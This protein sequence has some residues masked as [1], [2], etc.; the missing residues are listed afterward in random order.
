[1]KYL[2]TGSKGF[3]G[4]NLVLELKKNPENIITEYVYDVTR[5]F[6]LVETFDVIYHLAANTDTTFKNDV[7]MFENNIIGFLN[8]LDFAYKT[9]TKLIYASSGAIYGNDEKPLNAYGES[10]MMCDIIAKRYFD[11]IPLIGL[12]FFNVFGGGE[13]KK[14]KMASMI[15]QWREQ[16]KN[17]Q[18]PV[19][20]N[21]EFK[22]DFVYVKDIVKSLIEAQNLESGT[23][24]VGTGVAT[25]FRDVLNIVAKTMNVKIEPKFI[26]N[27]YLDKYQIFTKAD[28]SWGFKPE[29]T[30]ELGI[31]DYFE[32]YE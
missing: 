14:G 8:V 31:K 10:K 15:T 21:G 25:D 4:S 3:I 11:K 7:K 29:Y 5:R 32:N 24:D 2:I 6:N 27:P 19:I 28:I 23:Y 13:I 1:M 17:K 12:R 16:I 30:V 9:N 18:R 20:F 26:D 22:R